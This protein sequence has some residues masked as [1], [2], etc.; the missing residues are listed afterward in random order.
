MTKGIPNIKNIRTMNGNNVKQHCN[1]NIGNNN[2]LKIPELIPSQ[3]Q[4]NEGINQS[5]D[6]QNLSKP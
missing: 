5:I 4:S 6:S 3:Y 2:N 1:P